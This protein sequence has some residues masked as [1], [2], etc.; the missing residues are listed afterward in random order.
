MRLYCFILCLVSVCT[1]KAQ[2]YF[3][4]YSLRDRVLQ[5]TNLSPTFLS[6]NAFT[7]GLP[8][9]NF[10]L[11]NN[12]KFRISDMI[13]KVDGK[14]TYNLES[15]YKKSDKQNNFVV[16]AYLNV[17]SF[18]FS[19][20]KTRFSFMYNIRA[21]GVADYSKKILEIARDGLVENVRLAGNRVESN[22]YQELALG[23]RREF[24]NQRLV[25]GLR[26]KYLNG[27]AH[28]SLTNGEVDFKIDEK[29][30]H[31]IINTSNNRF[32]A[33]SP[34]KNKYFNY[35]SNSGFA[36][37]LGVHF[38]LN[39]K[40][41][42]DISVL[43]MGFIAWKEGLIKNKILNDKKDFV[44]KGIDL[45]NSA[46][47]KANKNLEEVYEYKDNKDGYTKRLPVK[48]YLSARY[49]INK[50]HSFSIASF[51]NTLYTMPSYSLGYVLNHKSVALGLNGIFDGVANKF[52]LGGSLVLDMGGF[53]FYIASDQL[54][55]I[56]GEILNTYNA[57]AQLGF[58]FFLKKSYR[59][60]KDNL[61]EMIQ[62]YF[63]NP[64]KRGRIEA[65]KF[66]KPII[67]E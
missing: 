5:N 21:N 49:K 4:M 10:G 8:A 35:L 42:F 47:N 36:A 66:Y 6:D 27:L 51:Y 1:L 24:F 54:L 15:M 16:D 9:L 33:L 7:I 18:G 59:R 53:Q 67:S 65:I 32:D 19:A 48:G 55:N 45:K 57:N 23:V 61:N 2:E 46:G 44:Y 64:K 63:E 43:D 40:I 62:G 17:F 13:H 58:N 20:G 14:W 52:K 25:V 38:K 31:W 56:G 37:D 29:T 12:S 39:E 34:I 41:D 3:S 22:T 28:Y 50:N 30:G 26:A 11:Y 60:T